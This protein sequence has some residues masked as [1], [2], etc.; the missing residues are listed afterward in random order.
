M[1]LF[2]GQ[3]QSH[4][5]TNCGRIALS[6]LSMPLWLKAAWKALFGAPITCG[7][8]WRSVPRCRHRLDRWLDHWLDRF[9][10]PAAVSLAAPTPCSGCCGAGTAAPG[11]DTE[12]A[13]GGE[14][15]QQRWRHRGGRHGVS[16][17][18]RAVGG[19]GESVVALEDRKQLGID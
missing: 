18:E 14:E 8:R 7:S 16:H 3:R 9:K 2:E 10:T 6:V 12:T 19:G 17:Q 1:G 15:Q 5:H 13:E 11:G 4:A